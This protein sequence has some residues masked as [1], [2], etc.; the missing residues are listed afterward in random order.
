MDTDKPISESVELPIVFRL[1]PHSGVPTYLQLVHQVER[2]LRLGLLGEGDQLPKVKDVVGALAIHPNT[3]L[4]AYKDLETRG[5]TYGRPGQGTFVRHAP[6]VVGL[7]SMQVLRRQL[8]DGFLPDATAAGLDEAG[9]T[10]VFQS[11][12]R[13]FLDRSAE[14]RG[15]SRSRRGRNEGAA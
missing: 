14:A 13:D 2:A 5:I 7:G 4:K 3:V 6:E 9:I 10:A 8:M 15:P 1:E 12:L 11:A